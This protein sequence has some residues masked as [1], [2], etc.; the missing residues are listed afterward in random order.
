MLWTWEWTCQP[1]TTSAPLPPDHP[2]PLKL[3]PSGHRWC[4]GQVEQVKTGP[5]SEDNTVFILPFQCY[6]QCQLVTE[7]TY[8]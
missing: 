8:Y 1:P 3:V 4:I 7:E 6:F 5:K 2:F